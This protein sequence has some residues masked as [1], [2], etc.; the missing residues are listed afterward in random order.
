[1]AGVPVRRHELGFELCEYRRSRLE[2]N[3]DLDRARAPFDQQRSEDEPQ[4]DCLANPLDF[5]PRG[6]LGYLGQVR[7]GTLLAVLDVE[8]DHIAAELARDRVYGF[9]TYG[10]WCAPFVI[11]VRDE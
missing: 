1:M 6:D 2:R 5:Q 9:D 8:E 4:A 10:H 11:L 7:N 3:L